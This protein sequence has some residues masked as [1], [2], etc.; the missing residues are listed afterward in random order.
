MHKV[1]NLQKKTLTKELQKIVGY[2][3]FMLYDIKIMHILQPWCPH[4]KQLLPTVNHASYTLRSRNIHVGIVDVT[5]Q[6][7]LRDRYNVKGFPTVFFSKDGIVKPYKGGRSLSAII[8]YCT[9]AARDPV[10]SLNENNYSLFLR[11]IQEAGFI[12]TK[13]AD[14][15]LVHEQEQ[16]YREIADEYAVYIDFGFTTDTSLINKISSSKP[17]YTILSIYSDGTIHNK[18]S[19]QNHT[20]EEMLKW[21]NSN[22]YSEIPMLEGHN[23]KSYVSQ[24]KKLTAIMCIDPTMV[25]VNKEM[26]QFFHNLINTNKLQAKVYLFI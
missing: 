14:T 3:F 17:S 11:N 5:S 10:S 2:L 1:K 18:L 23:F 22:Q 20:K 8:S 9:R 6:K 16:I 4:C 21:I 15:Q 7:K 13:S 19:P 24:E 12:F 26:K 25:K